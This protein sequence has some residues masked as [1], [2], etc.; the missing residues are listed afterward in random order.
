MM[1]MKRTRLL[2]ATATFAVALAITACSERVRSNA[3]PGMNEPQRELLDLPVLENESTATL[4]R[5]DY[6][7]GEITTL[8]DSALAKMNS[9]LD[10]LKAL[11]D[12]QKKDFDLTMM[13]YE[14]AF[15]DLSDETGN[16]TFMGYVSKNEKLRDEGSACEEKLGQFY[17]TLNSD[18]ALY[19]SLTKT[20]PRNA[21]EKR[22]HDETLRGFL[23]NGMA[24]PAA[25]REE[26]KKLNQE[27]SSLTTTFS[28]NLNNDT[29]SVLFTAEELAGV[30]AEIL[31]ELTRSPEGLYKVTTKSTDYTNVM[32]NATSSETRKKM[33][34]AYQN[35]AATANTELLEK[36]VQVRQK[37]AKLLGHATW[38]DAQLLGRMAPSKAAVLDF[39]GDLKAKLAKRNE[40]DLA[41]LLAYKKELDPAA[42]QV[43]IWD[44][45]YL[46]A[47]LKKR[48][49]SLDDAKIAE[50]FPADTVMK[51]MFEIYSN[52]LGV[53]YEKVD[54]AAV[55]AEGVSL[56]RVIDKNTGKLMAHFYSDTIPRE[57]KYGHAAAFPLIAGR[58]RAGKYTI[59][60]AS[61]VANFTPPTAD[62]PSLLKHDEVETLFHEFGHI[63]H[64]V[65]TKAPYASL[66]GTAV[67]QDFVE[68]PSQMLENWAWNDSV[69]NLIS[70]HYQTGEKLPVDLIAAMKK[71]K[72]FNQGYAYSRQLLYGFFDMAIHTADGPVDVTKVFNEKHAE[73]LGI[74]AVEGGH[75][76]AS[77]GHMMGGYDAGYYGYLW[78][79]VYAQ[80]MFSRFDAADLSNA[81]A[82]A[83]VG[84][85]YRRF[86]LERGSMND[87]LDLLKSFLGR[88][89]SQ[90]A[91]FK[92]LGI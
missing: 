55:W 92:K 81:E 27:L 63:M 46:S 43:D 74:P 7:E 42:T 49:Y 12:E 77:F 34:I 71:A 6:A 20:Q 23:E 83:K 14:N 78:S 33:L 65:L 54:G 10:A 51:G 90:D 8:C 11:S 41:K 70:G 72:D 17:A 9:R 28:A 82:V 25:Q 29:T 53:T 52:L 88:M 2:A 61:I 18:E 48:D 66:S 1:S 87:A 60:V 69:L 67:A 68:A 19:L 39:L 13:A 91:F 86:I 35:R 16:L 85:E 24:L 4:L 89:P 15:A 80:D 3:K 75:F 31:I 40:S 22:L 59:P 76:P 50:Y 26:L 56:Y 73:I 21:L 47:G 5:S 37:I 79:E 38:A 30:P 84:A 36:A 64:Q 62:K 58:A 44:I 32:E 57:G 45:A